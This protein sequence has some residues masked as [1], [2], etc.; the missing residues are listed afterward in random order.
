MGLAQ[1]GAPCDLQM[2]CQM[3]ET[4]LCSGDREDRRA[5][6]GREKALVCL[7]SISCVQDASF[8]DVYLRPQAEV[9]CLDLKVNSDPKSLDQVSV[10]HTPL[11]QDKNLAAYPQRCEA[12]P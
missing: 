5:G 2:R 10:A 9:G 7:S 11:G 12:L 1:A 4:Y 3:P 6:E 8:G